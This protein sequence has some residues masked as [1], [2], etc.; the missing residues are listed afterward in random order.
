MKRVWSILGWMSLVLV[1]VVAAIVAALWLALPLVSTTISIDGESFSLA[2]L[3]GGELALAFV[4]AVLASLAALAV[5]ALATALGLAAGAL[6]IGIGLLATVAVLALLASPFLVVGW[7]VWRAA[8]RP[9]ALPPTA[10][11]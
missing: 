11:A 10:T 6:G 4:A 5:G 3:S 8:R 2:N 1:I 7:L 9:R